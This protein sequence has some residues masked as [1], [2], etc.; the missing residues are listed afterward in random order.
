MPGKSRMFPYDCTV[1]CLTRE[2]SY[3]ARGRGLAMSGCLEDEGDT[4]VKREKKKKSQKRDTRC[5][6]KEHAIDRD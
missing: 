3:R 1:A 5:R 2:S 4:A 6:R